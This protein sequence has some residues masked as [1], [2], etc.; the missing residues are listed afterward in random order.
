MVDTRVAY[1][2][3]GRVLNP[4]S[5]RFHRLNPYLL[6]HNK[7]SARGVAMSEEMKKPEWFELA[8]QDA[9]SAPV[10][11][12]SKKLPIAAVLITGAVIA[13]GAFF[14]NASENDASAQGT[15]QTTTS[16]T[17]S[18]TTTPDAIASPGIQ[19]PT[20]GGVPAPGAKGGDG[21]RDGG[22]EWR[23]GREHDGDRDGDHEGRER[24]DDQ[25]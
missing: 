8:D 1:Y 3:I 16:S 24:H 25:D 18:A 14:A 5:Q 7:T 9:S 19:D 21:D 4:S 20:Q 17:P 10:N 23:E 6:S 11:K 13:T 12:A 2:A 22:H 15:S